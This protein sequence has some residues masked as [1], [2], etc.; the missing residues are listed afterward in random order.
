[1]QTSLK[2]SFMELSR[3]S[4]SDIQVI[5]RKKISFFGLS[6]LKTFLSKLLH[7]ENP[8]R[9]SNFQMNFIV[10]CIPTTQNQLS[11][12]WIHFTENF[13]VLLFLFIRR[14]CCVLYVGSRLNI[15][16]NLYRQWKRFY[17]KGIIERFILPFF[18]LCVCFCEDY[19]TFAKC[20]MNRVSYLQ[21]AICSPREEKWKVVCRVAR[22]TNHPKKTQLPLLCPRQIQRFFFT[23]KQSKVL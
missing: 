10:R 12:C 14:C 13:S 19:L 15:L 3:A 8:I 4:Q 17:G 20:Y 11:G 16:H 23:T 7:M 22:T 18:F 5:Q 1:M 6:T 21:N 2:W 9:T